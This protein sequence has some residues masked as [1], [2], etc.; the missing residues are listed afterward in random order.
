M[1]VLVTGGTG[2]VGAHAVAA[3]RDRG[4]QMRLLVR[5]P[6]RI[7]KAL[8]PLGVGDVE[9]AVGDITDPAS[10]ESAAQGCDAVLHAAAVYS[11]DR[12][13][14]RKMEETNVRGT[15]IVLGT[16]ARMG[17]DPVV[18]VSSV[19]ALFPPNGDTLTPDSPVKHPEGVYARSKADSERIARGLQER[20]VPVTIVYPGGVWGPHDPY[21]GEVPKLAASIL[22]G[23]MSMVPVGGVTVVDVRDLGRVF[24]G[25]MERGRGPRRYLAAGET[26]SLVDLVRRVGEITGRPLKARAL[27]AGLL[28]AVGRIND[29]VQR[30]LPFRL[31]AGFEGIYLAAQN[32]RCDNSRTW[33]DLGIAPRPVP[34]T[35]RDTLV[36]LYRDGYLSAKEV[37]QL[38]E[39]AE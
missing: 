28:L 34:E 13:D 7:G 16:A 8:G 37:G 35:I 36:W 10:V 30:V 27:P 9:H 25:A 33:S 26:V 38:V 4:H 20:G 39:A 2:F 18:H 32:P 21:Y 12:R 1:K 23:R 17:L 6:D 24:A 15:E 11:L 3:L 31:P 22:R 14:A 29:L 5:S 19:V